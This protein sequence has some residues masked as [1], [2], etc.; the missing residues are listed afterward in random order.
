MTAVTDRSELPELHL[1]LPQMRLGMDAIVERAVV[2]EAAGFG[3]IA[4]MDHLAPPM[5]D[6]QP[7]FD[8]VVTAAWVA[9][10]T[11]TLR[12]GHLVLCDAF[13]HPVVL[14]KQAVT[15]DHATG[16][17]LDLGIGWGS[18]PTEFP[19][20]GMGSTEPKERVDRFGE[21]LDVLRLLWSGDTVSYTGRHHTLVEARMQPAPL[22][23][24]PILIGGVGTRTVALVREH[25]QWWNVPV[26]RLDAIEEMRER[27]GD[28]RVSVQQMVTV[29]G[30]DD[31]RDALVA[32]ADRRWPGMRRSGGMLAGTPVELAEAFA[33]LR[34]RGVERIY[35]WLTDFAKP[36]TLE[37]LGAAAGS[38]S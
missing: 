15:L 5:A 37:A 33:A 4:F 2:A 18:V 12:I 20:F 23:R 10:R 28:A 19:T 6:H 21:S 35:A 29:V 9:A 13:H 7:M 17:R 16:G 36:A 38:A 3:G 11:S 22:D 14:A 27:A 32:Q 8:A 26:H 24:I 31:D 34:E 30:P 1:F 25:A